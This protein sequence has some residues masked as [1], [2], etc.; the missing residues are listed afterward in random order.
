MTTRCRW[1]AVAAGLLGALLAF[2]PSRGVVAQAPTVVT[3][4][5]DR[6]ITLLVTGDLPYRFAVAIERRQVV[7]G[8]LSG[9][10]LAA[11]PLRAERDPGRV[12][13]ALGPDLLDVQRITRAINEVD[14]VRRLDQDAAISVLLSAISPVIG[15]VTGRRWTDTSVVA[16]AT[17]E[18]RVL[19]TKSDGKSIGAPIV[20]RVTARAATLDAPDG[21]TAVRRRDQVTVRWRFPEYRTE[22]TAPV[23]GFHL[24]RKSRGD[25]VLTRV[26]SLPVPRIGGGRAEFVDVEPD[27]GLGL[28]YVVRA[29]A[30]GGREGPNS[31]PVVVPGAERRPPE[32]PRGLAAEGLERRVKLAW[33][34]VP[35]A[36]VQGYVVERAIGKSETYT[37]LSTALIPAESPQFEDSTAQA[38]LQY[39]YRVIAVDSAGNRSLPTSGISA[40]PF[41]KTPPAPPTG[42]VL[43]VEGTR[44]RLTW[45][46]SPSRDAGG[47][48]VYRGL[49]GDQMVRLTPRPITARTFVDSGPAGRGL[50][51]GSRWR[52]AVTTADRTFNESG[53]VA[54]TLTMPDRDPPGIPTSLALGSRA[55][56]S[57]LVQWTASTSLDVAEYVVE[58]IVPRA[59]AGRDSV[60]RTIVVAANR[61]LSLIDSGGPGEG[62]LHYRVV[63]RDRFGNAGPARRDSLARSDRT[64][65]SPPRFVVAERRAA[66]GRGAGSAGVLVRWE[67]VIDP[68]LAGYVVYR[69][70]ESTAGFVRITPRPVTVLE[71]IDPAGRPGL[72]YRVHAVDRSGNESLPSPYARVSPP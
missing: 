69:S 56:G 12:I 66:A 19:V 15:A 51:P 7:A 9:P 10:P 45:A 55:D 17:Y 13:D 6:A 36:D 43:A 71:Y 31:T 26:T 61:P 65:P 1:R 30:L 62:T 21:V 70:T 5:S 11:G 34:I 16:G 46:A 64:A 27:P 41:D 35:D 52:F 3:A 63:A 38:G 47:Y 28:T 59:V 42:L 4:A 29:L 44:V 33:G 50:G 53:S 68:R 24:Y 39:F 22:E 54:D 49:P 72:F 25:T 57:V 18:Y 23:I 8:Q 40:V 32:S 58:R 14:A 2:A 60:A 37:R 67:T 20:R 48:F